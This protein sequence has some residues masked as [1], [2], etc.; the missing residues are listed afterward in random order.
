M[1]RNKGSEKRM[2]LILQAIKS[3]LRKLE[4]RI[5]T[6]VTALSERID[7]SQ[8]TAD[9]ARSAAESA[10]ATADNAQATADNAML[11]RGSY[12][13]VAMDTGDGW[14]IATGSYEDLWDKIENGTCPRVR[15]VDDSGGVLS[16]YLP[17]ELFCD[18]DYPR[19]L[20]RLISRGTSPEVHV[21]SM[22]V[23]P[24]GTI[25]LYHGQ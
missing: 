19:V 14:Y 6:T 2:K 20:I 18:G 4:N 1:G 24:D 3:L 7:K 15:V 16:E 13:F 5:A 12:D 17:C 22:S 9:N 8:A 11:V 23:Y 25:S 21:Y 10:Q